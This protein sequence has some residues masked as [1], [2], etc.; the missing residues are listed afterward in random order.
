MKTGK[1]RRIVLAASIVLAIASVSNGDLIAYYDFGMTSPSSANMGTAGTVADGV[2]INGATIVDIDTSARGVEYALQLN[3]TTGSGLADCQYM[4]ITNGNDWF[5][6]IVS[7]GLGPF[8]IAAWVHQD[9]CT[10]ATW[11]T[12][13]SKG[14]DSAFYVGTGTPYGYGIDKFVFSYPEAIGVSEPL[15]SD[16]SARNSCWTHVVVTVDGV[17]YKTASLYING[18]LAESRQTWSSLAANTLDILIGAEPNKTDCQYGWNGL[19]DEVRIYDEHIDAQGAYDLFINTY[20]ECGQYP[21][22]VT[23]VDIVGPEKVAEGGEVQYAAIACI[24]YDWEPCCDVDVTSEACWWVI[25]DTNASINSSGLLTV[26]NIGT[27]ESITIYAGYSLDAFGLI[28]KLGE[29]EVLCSN[30]YHVD[31]VDGNDLNDGLSRE[32]AFATIQKGIDT[33]Q[34]DQTVLVW[35]GVYVESVYFIDK[36]I[37]VKSAADAAI[38]EAAGYNAVSF[39]TS[40][41]QDT[42]LANFV[43]RDS[44]TGILASTGTP[45]I[46]NITLVDNDLGIEAENGAEPNITN[47]ILWYNDYDLYRDPVPL[48]A[49]YSCI[50]ETGV[51]VGNISS[52]PLLADPNN[53]DYHLLSERGRYWATYDVWVLDNVSSPCID[54]GE[55]NVEPA[56]E[57][58]PNGGRIN[59][60]AFG[61]TGYASMSEWSWAGDINRDGVVNLADFAILADD[62][63]EGLSWAE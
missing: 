11:N 16:I 44:N 24:R 6:S 41:G 55:P 25:P 57:R 37:T 17:D 29:L 12:L 58:R 45:T 42:V 26:G 48:E 28:S 32:T 9:V 36:A 53:G 20:S 27:G 19:I 46:S 50:E 7:G 5:S 61:N 33:A 49:Q 38:L 1:M 60:G 23:S 56:A 22:W 30:E 13:I 54:S 63:L 34:D 39:Y 47:C 35:P 8:A 52:D 15:R 31:C 40:E 21:P 51:G 18:V 62:W 14:Y 43:I 4:N 59:M 10:T 3:N 2:L